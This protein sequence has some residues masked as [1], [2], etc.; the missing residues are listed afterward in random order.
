VATLI[1]DRGLA[2]VERPQNIDGW[3]RSKVYNPAY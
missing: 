2:R 1:F 3:I